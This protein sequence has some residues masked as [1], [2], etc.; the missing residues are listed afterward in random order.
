M[1]GVLANKIT[2][3]TVNAII[4]ISLLSVVIKVNSIEDLNLYLKLV[5]TTIVLI[6]TIVRGICFIKDREKKTD[7]KDKHK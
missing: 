6:F 1:L 5:T 7:E 4:D 2:A 3:F